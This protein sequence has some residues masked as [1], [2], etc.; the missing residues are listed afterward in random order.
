VYRK[1]FLEDG[2]GW[3][4][5]TELFLEEGVTVT[6]KSERYAAMLQ[7]L[8]QPRM[9]NIVENEAL[10]DLWLQQNRGYSSHS[11][12]VTQC[13]EMHVSW[14]SGVSEGDLPRPVR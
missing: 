8:L 5:H 3:L 11:L 13:F 2:G 1:Q 14:T 4:Q 7:N 9:E 12:N 10:G 6:V